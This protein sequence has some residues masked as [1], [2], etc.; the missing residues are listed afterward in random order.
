VAAVA[1]RLGVAPAT[2]RTW[3]RRYGLGPSDHAAGEHRR[4]APADIARLDVMRRLVQ[5]GAPPAEAA[6]IAVQHLPAAT[7]ATTPVP[8]RTAAVATLEAPTDRPG[9]PGGRILA[10]PGAGPEVRGLARAAMMLDAAAAWA[11][12]ELAVR[13]D[14]VAAAWNELLRPVLVGIGARWECT[15]TGV[16]VEHLLTETAIGVLRARGRAPEPVNG[17]PVLLACAPGEQHCLPLTA[18]AAA[19]AEHR[20]GVRL[21]GGGLP[22]E[23]LAAAV[24]RTGAAVVLV[25]A[26]LAEAARPAVL[27]ALPTL[28]PPVTVLAGGSGWV[29]PLP[30]PA[31]YLPNLDHA[32]DA[33]RGVVT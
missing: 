14:G 27:T 3:D 16:E 26:Q 15:G 18:L 1:R 12:V 19:L 24:R 25:F 8:A 17:R 4:Y 2:L 11:A 33:I 28:R 5:D 31:R 20:I 7:G 21:L 32:V 13:R 9:T 29:E 10:L 22:E 23:A 6:R 30:E